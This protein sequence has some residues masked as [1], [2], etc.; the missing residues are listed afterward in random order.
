MNTRDRAFFFF[1][2]FFQWYK[3]S[4]GQPGDAIRLKLIELVKEAEEIHKDMLQEIGEIVDQKLA[5]NNPNAIEVVKL[6]GSSVNIKNVKKKVK[7]KRISKY[8]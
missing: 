3:D 7:S 2:K 5:N 4:F 8:F 6:D 1:N